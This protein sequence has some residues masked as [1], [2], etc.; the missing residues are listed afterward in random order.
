MWG[1][2]RLSSLKDGKKHKMS[3]IFFH[4][5]QIHSYTYIYISFNSKN[6][7]GWLKEE[8]QAM[9]ALISTTLE[10]LGPSTSRV[11]FLPFTNKWSGMGMGFYGPLC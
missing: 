1:K 8:E 6:I 4:V 10:H 5:Y 7:Y 2:T 11:V 3:K 9:P